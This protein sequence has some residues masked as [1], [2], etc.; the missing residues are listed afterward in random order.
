MKVVRRISRLL[1]LATLA[2]T[3][4]AGTTAACDSDPA[5]PTP[6]ASSTAAGEASPAASAVPS[7]AVTFAQPGPVT[8]N[9]ITGRAEGNR[10]VEAFMPADIR[11]RAGDSIQWTAHGFEGHTITFGDGDDTLASLGEYLLP[12]PAN[13]DERIFN[14]RLALASEKQRTHDGT[15]EWI[16]SGFIGVPAEQTYTLTFTK[17]GLFTYLCLVHPFTMTGT[18][19]V[20]PAGAQ[21]ESP[22]TVSARGE[23]EL[24]EYLDEL[25]AE[26]QRLNDAAASAPGPGTSTIHYVQVGAITDHG[27]VAIY[28]P[29]AL[30]IVAGDTVIFQNDDRNFHNVIFRG[31]REL[32]SG[33]GIIPDPEGRGLNF[34]LDNASAIAVDPPPEGFDDQTFLSSGS[35]GVLQPRLTWTLRFDKP[36]TYLYACTIHVLGGMAGVINVR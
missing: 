10:D 36:G 30:D 9:V 28:T 17:E 35:L 19:T 1:L 13:P 11:V 25:G 5:D 20:E 2:A 8:F 27:Q 14:P 6:V 32:T 22:E 29:G 21:V 15:T 16:N 31:D 4:A 3:V 7:V 12:N 24:A 26:A 18:V 23:A 33:I 34:S